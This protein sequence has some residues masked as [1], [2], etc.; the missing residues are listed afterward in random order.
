MKLVGFVK[1]MCVIYT[2]NN[3]I[4]GLWGIKRITKVHQFP[5]RNSL[6]YTRFFYNLVKRVSEMTVMTV[7]EKKMVLRTLRKR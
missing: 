1:F 3:S 2:V 5:K 7:N 6:P 4:W